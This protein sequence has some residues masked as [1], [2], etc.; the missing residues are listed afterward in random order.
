MYFIDL[1]IRIKQ[2]SEG[3]S[4]SRGVNI[5]YTKSIH[6]TELWIG[7][8]NVAVYKGEYNKCRS[9][10]REESINATTVKDHINITVRVDDNKKVLPSV[11]SIVINDTA[12]NTRESASTSTSTNT[13]DTNDTRQNEV[14][15]VITYTNRV[16]EDNA[17]GLQD[18]LVLSGYKLNRVRVMGD[19]SLEGIRE[20]RRVTRTQT[21]D[22]NTENKLHPVPVLILQVALGP[23]EITL[24]T[25][26]Y[27]AFH[28]EQSW[29][30]YL[31]QPE[32]ASVYRAV[33]YGAKAIF[34]FSGFHKRYLIHTLGQQYPE[35]VAT[36]SNNM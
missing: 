25:S 22:N 17:F 4:G 24:L 32:F 35:S 15:I 10:I 7:R 16:Y 26:N 36:T 8:S 34:V 27:V 9:T 28:L 12:R 6:L 23:H 19:F 5:D 33:L 31:S 30:L 18:A 11:A 20:L 14:M 3:Y 29:S 13:N 2:D 21:I 1:F